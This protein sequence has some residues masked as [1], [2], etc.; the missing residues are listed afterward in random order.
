MVMASK[1]SVIMLS[2]AAVFAGSLI[3]AS[4]SVSNFFSPPDDQQESQAVADDHGHNSI[5]PL[6]LASG[7]PTDVEASGSFKL[8]EKA[9]DGQANTRSIIVHENVI[10]T[11]RHCDFCTAI[12]YTPGP[13]GEAGVSYK[14]LKGVDLTGAKRV[15]FF[16]MGEK[17]GEKVKFKVAGKILDIVGTNSTTSADSGNGDKLFKNR[18][19]GAVTKEITLDKTWK[20]IEVDLVDKKG[21]P[22]DLSKITHPFAL[23]VLKGSDNSKVVVYFKAIV[24]DSK[25]AK[26]PVP[27]EIQ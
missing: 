21:S 19:F 20:Q 14:A 9:G 27:T 12:E 3:I 23:Q 16:V 11:E 13:K 22:L 15:T 24:Y 6:A 1:P 10:D 5:L 7:F 2:I 17:G 8:S 26:N 18:K 4:S 25:V